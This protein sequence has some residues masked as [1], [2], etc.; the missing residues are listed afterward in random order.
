[1]QDK[2]KIIIAGFVV[3]VIF[4]VVG[5]VLLGFANETLDV[6]AGLFSAPEW[7]IWFPPLP[8]YEV[9]GFEGNML[10]NFVIGIA[11]SAL[12]LVLTFLIGW[13]ITRRRAKG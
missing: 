8:D 3:A 11:F 10:T 13:L 2:Y 6:I 4:V 12:I 7:E 5:V 1:M 9:P